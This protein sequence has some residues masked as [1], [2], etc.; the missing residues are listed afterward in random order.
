MFELPPLPYA[1]DALEPYIDEQTMHLHHDKHHAT[2]TANFNNA[3]KGTPLEG[4]TLGE[5][6]LEVDNYPPVLRNNAGGYVNHNLYW[7]V[8]GP[9]GT[10]PRPTGDLAEA[11]DRAFG[12]FE[13]F[14]DKFIAAAT[15]QFG[16]GWAWLIVEP[17]GNLAVISTPNQDHPMMKIGGVQ[18]GFPILLVDVWE[19]AYYLKYQNRRADYAAEFFQ[20]INWAAVEGLYAQAQAYYRAKAAGESPACPCGWQSK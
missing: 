6:F 1:Y 4:K 2:Y 16:S 13:A 8:I 17:S 10:A 19:H 14:R 3:L 7:Q 12:S 9:V 20:V 15:G 18:R 11:I 5:I